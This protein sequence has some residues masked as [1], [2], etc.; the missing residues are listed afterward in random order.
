DL[1]GYDG[2]QVV[3]LFPDMELGGRT[4]F[5]LHGDG[6]I[7]IFHSLSAGELAIEIYKMGSDGVTPVLIDSFYTVANSE[8]EKAVFT[9][10]HK[11]TKNGTEITE[12]AYRSALNNYETPLAEELHWE[13]IY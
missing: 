3:F 5:S 7:E 12:E 9:Y 8:G 4:H 2:S 11:G 6:V 13:E 1:Y 10:Y